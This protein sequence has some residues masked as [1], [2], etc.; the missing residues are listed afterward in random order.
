[1]E[2]LIDPAKLFD[3]NPRRKDHQNNLECTFT[4]RHVNDG[5]RGGSPPSKKAKLK[6]YIPDAQGWDWS[7]MADVLEEASEE[8]IYSVAPMLR[9]QLCI[10]CSVPFTSPESLINKLPAHAQQRR[11]WMAAAKGWDSETPRDEVLL[12]LPSKRN[13]ETPTDFS[14]TQLLDTYWKSILSILV[15][16]HQDYITKMWEQGTKNDAFESQMVPQ[17]VLKNGTFASPEQLRKAQLHDLEN[18][19]I[20]ATEYQGKWYANFKLK[21]QVD[22][23]VSKENHPDGSYM[24]Y[25]AEFAVNIGRKPRTTFRGIMFS[26]S[27]VLHFKH[28][29][30]SKPWFSE[31]KMVKD[32]P[33]E[34]GSFVFKSKDKLGVDV[35]PLFEDEHS[36]AVAVNVLRMLVEY[37]CVEYVCVETDQPAPDYATFETILPA[38]KKLRRV[39]F[40]TDY[41][42]FIEAM[43][44][45]PRKRNGQQA[46]YVSKSQWE[47]F[48]KLSESEKVEARVL[49]PDCYVE[50]DLELGADD[51]RTVWASYMSLW[52]LENA[53]RNVN[54]DYMGVC[55]FCLQPYFIEDQM[56]ISFTLGPTIAKECPTLTPTLTH[57][58]YAIQVDSGTYVALT[59]EKTVIEYDDWDSLSGVSLMNASLE[60][61]VDKKDEEKTVDRKIKVDPDE[62]AV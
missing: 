6:T 56:Y 49:Y 31:Q 39:M 47:E 12:G 62:A 4:L 13:I 7:T 5:D 17:P 28:G 51:K 32:N 24:R 9:R 15:G 35:Q 48:Q 14:D 11:L 3:V 25:T 54:K 50:P 23:N 27:M 16:T 38:V 53:Y 22:S 30:H 21:E 2:Y 55:T 37:N 60:H 26:P 33:S 41:Y 1:M 57:L 20:E 59:A 10:K 45:F 42:A 40:A 19:S 52:T 34:I 8:V 43:T 44:L 46:Q 58:R 29:L 61:K 36:F 18:T